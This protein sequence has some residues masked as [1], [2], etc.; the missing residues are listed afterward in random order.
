MIANISW[1]P[2]TE[3]FTFIISCNP[4]NDLTGWVLLRLNGHPLQVL[5]GPVSRW[6]ITESG[7]QLSLPQGWQLPTRSSDGRRKGW[8]A[9][10]GL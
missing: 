3:H 9:R 1:V 4:S 2:V 10:G 5:G 6:A 7:P 8:A